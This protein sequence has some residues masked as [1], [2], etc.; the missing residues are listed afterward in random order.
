ML[1]PP[2]SAKHKKFA[3]MGYR[4]G[5]MKALRAA[6]E[7][8]KKQLAETLAM[9]ESF[10]KFPYKMRSL[11]KQTVKE[12]PRAPGGPKRRLTQEEE[13]VACAEIEALRGEYGNREAIRQIALKREVSARTMYRIWGRHRPKKKEQL[14]TAP[15]R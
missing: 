13:I 12:L 9:I 11:L 4:A 14:R 7:P 2:F 5:L 15:A 3:R 8:K 6:P 10:K 1:K